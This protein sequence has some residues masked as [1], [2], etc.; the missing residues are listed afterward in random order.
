MK[1]QEKIRKDLNDAMKAKEEE[2]KSALRVIL[3]EMSRLESKELSDDDVVR[4]LK[5]LV[6]S[7]KEVLEKK[8]GQ[9]LFLS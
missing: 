4:L 1:L 5:K 6:K 2:K 7:E 9:K 8:G 3:G